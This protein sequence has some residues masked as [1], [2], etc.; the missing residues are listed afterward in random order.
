MKKLYLLPIIVLNLFFNIAC[1]N[2]D[3]KDLDG[4]K[5]LPIKT[6]ELSLQERISLLDDYEIHESEIVKI[7]KKFETTVLGFSD[8]KSSSNT[9]YYQVE[10]KFYFSEEKSKLRTTKDENNDDQISIYKVKIDKDGKKGYALVSADMRHLGVIAFIP[11]SE[12]ATINIGARE[13]EKMSLMS[14]LYK[15]KKFNAIKDS[16]VRSAHKKLE[17]S[18]SL[19]STPQ[20]YEE[21]I[22]NWL[23]SPQSVLVDTKK[24]YPLIKTEWNQG[25]P[26]N[27]M[28]A[29]CATGGGF[30]L[31]TGCGVVAIAQAIA[32]CE[33]KM[34]VYA[35]DMD[36]N[37]IK[38]ESRLSASSP[39]NIINKVSALMK[40]IGDKAGSNPNFESCEVSTGTDKIE[41]VLPMVGMKCDKGRGWDWEVISA[42][43][44]NGRIVHVSGRSDRNTGH[45]WLMDA[46]IQTFYQKDNTFYVHCNFGWSSMGDGY[47]EVENNL[48][49]ENPVN[50]FLKNFRIQANISKK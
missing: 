1:S 3:A 22:N 50:T 8:L 5:S 18:L 33:P 35:Y 7:I 15:I 19:R 16:L 36:W 46:Y 37:N 10:N 9:T 31:Y 40:W 20:T 41:T 27:S 26:Y 17:L 48:E 34:N 29:S 14:A 44:K 47:Y 4:D 30:K 23:S 39:K 25:V 42:S 28:M 13:M 38:K 21:I 11:A 24:K 43:L 6:I 12:D 2:D 49:F 45:G 32:H